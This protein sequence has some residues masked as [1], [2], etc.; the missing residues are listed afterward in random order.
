[1]TTRRTFTE[2]DQNWFRDVSGDANPLHCDPRWADVHFPG[3]LVV[4][5]I[6]ALLWAL[7]QTCLL[8]PGRTL[9]TISATFVRPI[10]LGDV[11]TIEVIEDSDSASAFRLLI[12]GGVAAVIRTKAGPP[13]SPLAILDTP[14]EPQVLRQRTLDQLADVAGHVSPP[15]AAGLAT[16]FPAATAAAGLSMV[17]AL[18]S[19]S[20]LVGME[21]PGLHAV[22]SE[23]S[24]TSDV[25]ASEQR[26]A[27]RVVRVDRAF[28]RVGIAVSGLGVRGTVGAFV[29]QPAAE[30]SDDDVRALVRPGEFTGQ[31]P[32]IVGGSG[33]LGAATVRLLAAGGATPVVTW[34]QSREGA[35]AIEQAVARLGGRCLLTRL[36]VRAPSHGLAELTH[37]GWEGGEI[38]YFA[39]PRIFRRRMEAFQP[40]DLRAF[41]DVYVDGFHAVVQHLLKH[42]AGKT[43]RAFYPS[44]VAVTDHTPELL[45]YAMAK[46]AGERLCQAMQRVHPQLSITISR[47][48]RTAT[49]QTDSFVKVAA[50][51]PLEVMMPIVRTVQGA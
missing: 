2:A 49:R 7:E 32:L 6:H 37:A 10:V 19:L 48:P 51:S 47:L 1:M 17:S 11:V 34:H 20:T 3:A 43:L 27:Y 44:S 24:I 36:D 8:R 15:N 38:Y 22:F 18:A 41:L 30:P 9:S 45:E 28:S 14:R 40:R 12:D 39:T 26:L 46:E 31:H 23:F 25:S 4:H 35:E 50:S 33:G 21:C 16:A 5:G 29:G 13:S 42:R